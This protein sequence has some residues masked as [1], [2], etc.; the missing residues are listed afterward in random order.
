MAASK[1]QRKRWLILLLFIYK[2]CLP[3][4]VQAVATSGTESGIVERV[5]RRQNGDIYFLINSSMHMSCDNEN[6]SYLIGEDK[7]VKEQELF[8]GNNK[9]Y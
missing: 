3:D 1:D 6:T 8:K 9:L 2:V 5:S 7:C 4:S